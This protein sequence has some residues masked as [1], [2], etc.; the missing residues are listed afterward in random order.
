MTAPRM[1]S[2]W[3]LRGRVVVIAEKPKAASKIA[4]SILRSPKT[5][6]YKGVPYYVGG[7]TGQTII[8]LSA[9]GHL[10][11]LSSVGS[12]YPVFTYEWRPIYE[13]ESGASHARKFLEL[14]A[15]ECRGADYYVNACDYDVEGSVIGYL[16]IK[17]LGDERRALRAKFSTLAHEDLRR[18]FGSLEPLDY[19]M[20]EAG[21]CRH[22]LDWLWGINVSRALMRSVEKATGRRVTL[23]AGRVQ[24]P[25]LKYVA[26]NTLQRN[27][28]VPLPLYEVEVE[29]RAG[30]SV[31]R[32]SLEGGRRETR[33]EALEI[34]R[35]IERAKF[36]KVTAVDRRVERLKPPP[37]FNLG[38][39]QSEAAR[40]YGFSPFRTQ[41][42]AEDLYLDALI[43]Y[44]RT[45]SQKLPPTIGYAA[46]LRRLAEQT[47]YRKLV[48]QLLR[49]TGGFL[50][51]SEGKKEDPAH[52]A[53]YPTGNMPR[54]L[55]KEHAMIYD[56]IVRRFLAT[57]SRDAVIEGHK[58]TLN[59][60]GSV[61]L[62]AYVEGR[63][64]RELGWL[65]YYPFVEVKE[66]EMP[67]LAVG[68][69][70]E[71]VRVR[72][73]RTYT[74]PAKR[75]SRI[76][77]LKWMEEVGIGTEST[78]ARIIE[79][80]FK[81]EYVKSTREGVE[82]TELG[83]GVIDTI[84]SYF[85]ELVRV[86]LT[87]KFENLMEEI[88]GGRKRRE[89]VVAEA[90]EVLGML[91]R[92]FGQVEGEVGA[93]LGIRMNLLKPRRSCIICG[94]ESHSDNL[95][96]YHSLALNALREGYSI[97]S[98]REGSMS[99]NEYLRTLKGLASTG[100]WVKELIAA[101]EGGMIQL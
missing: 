3:E 26:D 96:K 38:D 60:E 16:I 35:A 87:R 1:V 18:A 37:P 40:I 99:F 9:A 90:K 6:R 84:S 66:K 52:P 22:E 88:R 72:V 4:A 31:L 46:I 20:I 100:K 14:L 17:F 58:I 15:K 89:Q 55:K 36:F 97:W 7:G 67:K 50:R 44:P 77:I 92:R 23:S 53:I 27:T 101:I 49:E 82:A 32:I 19:P 73:E 71:V 2:L 8:V 10:Y 69:R 21:L 29:V 94:R 57:F 95:C 85:P 56:L 28:F 13:V 43:S 30:D 74:R 78:R 79:T 86:D 59:L 54:A 80:L 81:R 24:T 68:D 62:R 63:R 39:L 91:L 11:G 45:N 33:S 51:P 5:L 83:L 93:M 61:S 25:T 65:S 34:A 12:G 70:L 75:Y 42:I 47:E 64:I 41:E 76:D 48:D 98:K